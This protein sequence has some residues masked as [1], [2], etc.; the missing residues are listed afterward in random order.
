MKIIA[1]DRVAPT[2]TFTWAVASVRISG[3][4]AENVYGQYVKSALRYIYSL[5]LPT[6]YHE[7][8][9]FSFHAL[10]TA[11]VRYNDGEYAHSIHSC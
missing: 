2:Y 7:R 5:T 4:G 1:F 8:Y 6:I 10:E 11:N 3:M 9:G